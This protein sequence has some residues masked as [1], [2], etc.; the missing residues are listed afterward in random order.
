VDTSKA[1]SWSVSV[2]RMRVESDVVDTSALYVGYDAPKWIQ[3][4]SGIA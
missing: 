3:L 4:K 2:N 1:G